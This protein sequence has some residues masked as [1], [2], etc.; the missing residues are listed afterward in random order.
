MKTFSMEQTFVLDEKRTSVSADF[1]IANC[2]VDKFILNNI[3]Y[4]SIMRRELYEPVT[5]SV[6]ES[7]VLSL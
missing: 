5:Q 6:R 7:K 2:T 3:S 4:F 1:I